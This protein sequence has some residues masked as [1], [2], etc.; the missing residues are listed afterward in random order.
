M[1]PSNASSTLKTVELPAVGDVRPIRSES[2]PP[3]G[4]TPI[5]PPIHCGATA[6]TD[7]EHSELDR[8]A[9][10]NLIDELASI[11][12]SITRRSARPTEDID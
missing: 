4:L 6:D 7:E 3:K 10:D 2:T 5:L 1:P 8:M 9:I 12:I 11:A